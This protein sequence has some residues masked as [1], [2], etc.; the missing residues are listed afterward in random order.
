MTEHTDA[1][2]LRY[3]TPSRQILPILCMVLSKDS[4]Q[5]YT[6]LWK[7]FGFFHFSK[8]GFLGP[9]FY[10]QYKLAFRMKRIEYYNEYLNFPMAIGEISQISA[11]AVFQMRRLMLRSHLLRRPTTAAESKL[12]DSWVGRIIPTASYCRAHIYCAAVRRISNFRRQKS[13]G[14]RTAAVRPPQK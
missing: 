8:R 6:F 9:L 3:C 12:R 5:V 1:K 7:R 14:G 11:D 2:Q 10:I 13:C 4:Q